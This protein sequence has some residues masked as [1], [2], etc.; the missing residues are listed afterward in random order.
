MWE[1]VHYF[2]VNNLARR[3][4]VRRGLPESTYAATDRDR[5]EGPGATAFGDWVHGD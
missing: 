3:G 2:L 4:F 1:P 5:L